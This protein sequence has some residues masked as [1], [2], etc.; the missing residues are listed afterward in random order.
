MAS[1]A[2]LIPDPVDLEEEIKLRDDFA[3]LT[4]FLYFI[5]ARRIQAW[6]RGILTRNHFRLLHESAVTI[7]RHWRGYLIRIF[8]DRY[9]V[10]RVHQMWQDY[11]D[12]MAT[13]IQAFWRG[14][15]I[16]KTV[17]D[18]KKMKRWLQE[19]Y[20]K[21]EEAVT[22]MKKFHQDEIE[23]IQAMMER[24]SMQW[25]LF[26]LFKLH[27]LLRT[28]QQPGVIT[29]IDN[30]HLTMIE[31]M[32]KCF[33]YR[34]YVRRKRI[35][36]WKK[37]RDCQIDK[38]RTLL[39]QG[40]YYERCERAIREIERKVETGVVP[41][42]RSEPYEKHER[43]MRKWNRINQEASLHQACENVGKTSV[44]AEENHCNLR[45]E[46][47]SC[48]SSNDLYKQIEKMECHLDKVC[49]KCPIHEPSCSK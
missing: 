3:E 10:E 11:Y 22:N 2:K 30:T 9:L 6:M 26:I 18:I 48:A 41:I 28:N 24:E 1:V 27:H 33:E 42:F 14:Y 37:C 45:K 15:W 17:F 16:R 8:V 38:K 32:L 13:R 36:P 12:E 5:A 49:L 39:L 25:I 21:N 47:A 35:A 46:F 43:N 7:Q 31:E 44:E 40:T 20:K 23:R 29:R 34:H 4:R 19:V